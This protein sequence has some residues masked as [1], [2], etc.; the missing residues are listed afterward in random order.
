[1]DQLPVVFGGLV[2]AAVLWVVKTTNDTAKTVAVL[3]STIKDLVL[4]EIERQRV[5]RHDTRNDVQ[6]V[7]SRVDAIDI[8]IERHEKDIEA[9]WGGQNRRSGNDR[10]AEP[11]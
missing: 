3:D 2:L 5:N 10:R 6:E 11:A 8:H 7:S 9:L 1:M 4:P